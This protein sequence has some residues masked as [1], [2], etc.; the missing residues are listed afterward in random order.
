MQI[1]LANWSEREFKTLATSISWPF[2]S[3]GGKHLG[4]GIY[5]IP[6]FW[7]KRSIPWYP[8]IQIM[9]TVDVDSPVTPTLTSP[10]ILWM[11]D[12][13]PSFTTSIKS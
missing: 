3:T 4:F 6:H 12:F 7:T 8:H 9:N 1:T 2:F 11:L 10:G 5:D 13:D